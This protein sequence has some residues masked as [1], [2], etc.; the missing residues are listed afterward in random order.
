MD[1]KTGRAILSLSI[2]LSIL[3]AIVSCAGIFAAGFLVK[4]NTVIILSG[5]VIINKN[6]EL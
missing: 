5:V 2:P 1:N 4:E 3:T 6:I